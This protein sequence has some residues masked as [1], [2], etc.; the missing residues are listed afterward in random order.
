MWITFLGKS[1]EK[2]YKV[3]GIVIFLPRFVKEGLYS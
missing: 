2:W 3:V 1:G